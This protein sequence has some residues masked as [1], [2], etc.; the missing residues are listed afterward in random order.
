MTSYYALADLIDV[1]LKYEPTLND[2]VENILHFIEVED[3]VELAHIL[4]RSIETL[5]E[6]LNQVEDT[7]LAFGAIDNKSCC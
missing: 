6:H 2:L 4:E 5:H 1:C 7:Q 3:E